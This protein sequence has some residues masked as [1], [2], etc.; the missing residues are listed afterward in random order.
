MKGK[1]RIITKLHRTDVVICS[2][3]REGNPRLIAG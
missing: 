3:S 1:T 2:C